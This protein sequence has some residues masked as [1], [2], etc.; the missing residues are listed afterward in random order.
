LFALFARTNLRA[1]V[2]GHT[3]QYRDRTVDG[4]RH[5]WVPSTA[6]YLPDEV[7][8]RI[9][10]K[11][12]GVGVLDLGRDAFRFNLVCP[13]GVTRHSILDHPVYPK[14]RTG[15]QMTPAPRSRSIS[16]GA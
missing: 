9:G 12:T 15:A 3:H 10:E 16:A 5:L 7:Q 13:D 14:Y 8:D 2:S 1:V 6:Y 4:L 11:I